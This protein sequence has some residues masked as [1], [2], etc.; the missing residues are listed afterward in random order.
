[1]MV[2]LPPGSFEMGSSDDDNARD[3][4]QVTPA[5]RLSLAHL[6]GVSDRDSAA[7]FMAYEHP[8]HLVTIPYK[9]AMSKAPISKREFEEFVSVTKYKTGPCLFWWEHGRPNAPV[10]NAWSHPGFEQSDDEPVVCVTW[11]DANAYIAW[12]N[13]KIKD[14]ESTGSS[15]GTYRLPS[16]SE[17]EYAA[18]A[19]TTTSRWWGDQMDPNHAQCRGC[20]EERMRTVPSCSFPPNQ[21][22]LY[23]MLG[24]VSEI[25]QDCW[26]ANYL[27]AP[28]TGD[29]WLSGDC[30]RRVSRGGSWNGEAWVTRSTT[31]GSVGLNQTTNGQGFRVVKSIGRIGK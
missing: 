4:S 14:R 25:V 15:G 7:K 8:R 1:M 24:N 11:K 2:P 31:R 6:L 5:P 30:H 17:W 20:G 18:R 27:G 28:A 19:G 23:D 10:S 13:T 26:H 22:G 29:P 9:F 16:E 12:L 21:F 3:L